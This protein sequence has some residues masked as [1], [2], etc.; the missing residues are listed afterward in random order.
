M[1]HRMD[2]C[3][4]ALTQWTSVLSG[5]MSVRWTRNK[6]THGR[7]SN[8]QQRTTNRSDDTQYKTAATISI[9][10]N[11]SS[12]SDSKSHVVSFRLRLIGFEPQIAIKTIHS[13]RF[14]IRKV[15]L[16]NIRNTTTYIYQWLWKANPNNGT[17]N[18][19][20]IAGEGCPD[21]MQI[22]EYDLTLNY[23]TEYHNHGDCG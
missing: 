12:S 6:Y 13:F 14:G 17:Q 8:V 3:S 9:S 5:Q 10:N 21:E 23:G 20:G 11:P 16:E 2:C 4:C 18:Q 15:S 19:N 1:K 7:I 22:E